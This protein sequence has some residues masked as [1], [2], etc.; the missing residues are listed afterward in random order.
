MRLTLADAAGVRMYSS[1]AFPGSV[2]LSRFS[3]R[4]NAATGIAIG[5][6]GDLAL[7]Q[8][9]VESSTVGITIVP[10][11]YDLSRAVGDNVV[12]RHNDTNVDR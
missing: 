6:G 2:E 1:S 10:G 12:F 5:P 4:N 11:D 3:V 7:H 8:G 9:E